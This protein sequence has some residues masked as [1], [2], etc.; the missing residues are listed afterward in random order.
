[1]GTHAADGDCVDCYLITSDKVKSGTAVQCEPVGLLLQDE[2]GEIDHKVLAAMPGQD[3]LV[4]PELLQKLQEFI[5]SIFAAYPAMEIRVGPILSRE[6]A[7]D[8]LQKSG[9]T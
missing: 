2:D 3:V 6:A 8:H 5:Y 1:M 4:G 7:L 9:P